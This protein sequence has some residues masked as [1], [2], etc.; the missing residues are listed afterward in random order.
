VVALAVAAV[1]LGVAHAAA[2]TP[3][4]AQTPA[5]AQTPEERLAA[6]GIELPAPP[7]PVANYVRAVTTGNLVFLAGHVPRD[8]GGEIV[9]GKLGADLDV[10]QGAAAAR[11]T[12]IA[13]LASLRAEI[14]SLD[15]VARVVRVTGMVNSTPEFDQQ[16]AVINGCSDLIVE[17]FGERGKHAR[18]AVGM[19]SLP[20]QAAVEIEMVVEVAEP[21]G[22]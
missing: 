21:A 13:L 3:S 9:R 7:A 6:L 12:A 16:P 19:V 17:V 8:E 5:A 20:L 11:L 2:Q 14:G 10:E 18:S 22:G 15:R 4:A 1:F